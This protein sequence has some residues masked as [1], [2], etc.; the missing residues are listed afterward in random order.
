[1]AETAFI[2]PIT[3]ADP[4]HPT[5]RGIPRVSFTRPAV[6]AE[7]D[8]IVPEVPPPV[9]R[10]T[11]ASLAIG[12][13]VIILDGPNKGKKAVVVTDAGAGIVGVAGPIVP[14]EEID[15]DVLLATSTKLELG[16]V[17]AG[18]APGAIDAAAAKVPELADYLKAIFTLKPGDRPHLMKF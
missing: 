18:S 1:M 11:R 13:V 4:R 5:W 2:A 14:F 3:Q 8:P 10:Q 6:A 15:Q 17:D 7:V 16:A 9:V 12:T